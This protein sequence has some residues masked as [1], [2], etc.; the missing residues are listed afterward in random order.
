VEISL[1]WKLPTV[2]RSE[3]KWCDQASEH[4]THPKAPCCL[5]CRV[6]S[7]HVGR[8][9]PCLLYLIKSYNTILYHANC[10]LSHTQSRI[11]RPRPLPHDFLVAQK[12]RI[13]AI[14]KYLRTCGTT[15]HIHAE[16]EAEREGER[17]R[18]NRSNQGGSKP[19]KYYSC[20]YSSNRASKDFERA[21]A[22]ARTA[23]DTINWIRSARKKRKRALYIY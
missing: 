13:A 22:R 7:Y 10:Q 2:V 12:Q 16:A 14:P 9:M 5:T 23:M 21:H 20:V 1:S 11:F 18:L 19:P 17:E 8:A 3:V 4:Q 15:H 6:V